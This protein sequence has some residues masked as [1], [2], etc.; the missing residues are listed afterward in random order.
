MIGPS[1][2]ID[3]NQ[4]GEECN[5]LY[6][7]AQNTEA[8]SHQ[9]LEQWTR[10]ATASRL[11]AWAGVSNLTRTE[12]NQAKPNFGCE[13]LMIFASATQFHIY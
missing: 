9:T 12:L 10:P 6:L 3:D 2:A 13:V 1:I 11:S 8:P 7:W 5:S 4:G